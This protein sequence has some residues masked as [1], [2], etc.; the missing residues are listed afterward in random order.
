MGS[1]SAGSV[2]A[3]SFS[4]EHRGNPSARHGLRYRKNERGYYCEDFS[5]QKQREAD[6]DLNPGHGG[7]SAES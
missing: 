4:C 3:R 5:C 1:A 7:K 6:R 2:V